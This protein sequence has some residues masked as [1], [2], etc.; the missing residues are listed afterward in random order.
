MIEQLASAFTIADAEKHGMSKYQLYRLL[1]EGVI[2]RAARGI[3]I[4]PKAIDP[5][6][7]PLAA[8]T[9]GRLSSTLC[10]T[11]ALAFHGMTDAIPF[12]CDIALPRG[13]RSIAGVEHAIWH[14]FNEATFAIGREPLPNDSAL[15]LYIYSPERCII[16]AF[17]LAHQ[18]GQD[19]A[20]RALK[21]WLEKKGNS[22]STLLD[23]AKSF[24]KAEPSLRITLEI[25]L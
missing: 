6:L 19:T 18:E 12:G 2:E 1:S 25:L 5:A 15:Q 16:D 20:T 22:P 7:A 3:Y 14:T 24:P 8:A 13:T 17:R 11:S 4:L 9:A 23:M 10:L 21:R